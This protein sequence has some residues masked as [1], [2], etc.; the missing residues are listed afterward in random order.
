MRLPDR[1][2]AQKQ[3]ALELRAGLPPRRGQRGSAAAYNSKSV[4][5]REWEL[6]EQA[7]TAYRKLVAH[8]QPTAPVKNR[9]DAVA[10]TEARLSE[11]A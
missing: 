5:R 4:R 6:A 11:P 3:R 8:W 7:E 2:W 10:S 9:T 1:P